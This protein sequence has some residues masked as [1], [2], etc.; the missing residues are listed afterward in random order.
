M[1]NDDHDNLLKHCWSEQNFVETT[2]QAQLTT[3]QFHSLWTATQSPTNQIEPNNATNNSPCNCCRC[4][5]RTT[6]NRTPRATQRWSAPPSG[7]LKINSDGAF[8]QETHNGGWG[9][10]VKDHQG[11]AIISGRS[12]GGLGGS[13][14]PNGLISS[15]ITVAKA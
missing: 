6:S 10:I 13:S 1:H 5:G 9:F 8:I 14:P 3:H 2:A 4:C 7:Q 12:K 15:L 11:E